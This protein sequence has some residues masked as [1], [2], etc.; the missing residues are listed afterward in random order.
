MCKACS[1]VFDAQNTFSHSPAALFLCTC[2]YKLVPT[3]LP[4]YSSQLLW[5][6]RQC[7][8]DLQ[9]ESASKYRVSILW[10]KSLRH[11]NSQGTKA[12]EGNQINSRTWDC[13]L[14]GEQ[15]TR[16]KTFFD[17]WETMECVQ[18][19]CFYI[20]HSLQVTKDI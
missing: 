2:C 15:R 14:P 4:T 12:E 18:N 20:C 11:Q 9:G 8:R 10:T 19:S 1:Q 6:C 7:F 5:T 17:V 16:W 13:E 3:Y